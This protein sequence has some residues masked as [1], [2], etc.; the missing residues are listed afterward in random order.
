MSNPPKK[1]ET[2][3]IEGLRAVSEKPLFR[4][5]QPAGT[6]HHNLPRCSRFSQSKCVKSSTFPQKMAPIASPPLL[7]L[8]FPDDRVWS[9]KCSKLPNWLIIVQSCLRYLPFW[10]VFG[11]FWHRLYFGVSEIFKIKIANPALDISCVSKNNSGISQ[12]KDKS[13]TV[14]TFGEK[15]Y[16]HPLK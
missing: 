6:C 13:F 12:T 10:I 5:D 15:N 16:K 8:S 1:T 4:G 3:I 7:V 11:W 14:L 2:W 9:K